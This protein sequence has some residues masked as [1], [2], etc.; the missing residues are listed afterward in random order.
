[1]GSHDQNSQDFSARSVV[2]VGNPPGRRLDERINKH[3]QD[4]VSHLGTVGIRYERVNS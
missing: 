2:R 3:N 4:A 1:M